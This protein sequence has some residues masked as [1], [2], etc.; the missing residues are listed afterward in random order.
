LMHAWAQVY[1][2]WAD[3]HL[4]KCDEGLRQIDEAIETLRKMR[5]DQALSQILGIKAE[6]SLLCEDYLGGLRVIGE[7]LEIVGQTGERYYESALWKLRGELQ[8]AIN[9]KSCDQA[10]SDFRKAIKIAGSQR[11]LLFELRAAISLGRLWLSQDRAHEA[12]S[13]VKQTSREIEDQLPD[14]DRR[15]LLEFL[16]LCSDPGRD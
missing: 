16:S 6:I 4:G 13:T 8:L 5:T 15:D 7:A 14:I 3:A 10:E 12:V 2:G 11:A 1:E 9:P